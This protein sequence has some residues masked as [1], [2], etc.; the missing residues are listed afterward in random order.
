MK[1]YL[2]IMKQEAGPWGG[3]EVLWASAA[4][5][6]VRQGNDVRVSAKDWGGPVPQIERLRSAGC[7]IF[8]R[9]DRYR[10]PRFIPR[11]IRKIVPPPP[12]CEA[13]IRR[14]GVDADLVVIAQGDN[15]DGLEWLEAARVVG[16]KYAVISQAA[17]AYWWP[18][19]E[20]V[21][22]LRGAYENAS[23][24]YFVSQ[25]NLELT[26][27]QLGSWLPNA[28]VVRQA[29]N[30]AYDARP[31]W[32][33]SSDGELRL[34]CVARLDARH[35][36][37]DLLFDVLALPHWRERNVR[38]SMFGEG[39]NEQSLR[40]M[41]ELLGLTSVDFRGETTDI[42]RVWAEH[43][44]LVLASRFE[45]MSLAVI[46][47]ML[48]GRPCVTTEV[49]GNR[50]LIADNENGFLAK[51]AT[52]EL[53]DEALNRAWDSRHRLYAMGEA[54]ATDVRRW[55]PRDPGEELA[56]ELSVLVKTDSE[57]LQVALPSLIET[58]R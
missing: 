55:V 41:A 45:G 40:R 5:H 21:Q 23:A 43:H 22:K 54:A 29:F 11:Q 3:S 2:F 6:L 56:R 26:R 1:K 33:P 19:D 30:V 32:P 53:F 16:R 17:G 35:K 9:P 7:R 38:V 15:V 51:A 28:K 49:G 48:C 14:L 52:V 57:A 4:G 44:A 42:E 58:S 8:L 36:G 25:E 13:Q 37:Q 20:A 27:R 34:A 12:F 47:A 18:P 50:E 31:P 46:E 39:H 10:I 24:A